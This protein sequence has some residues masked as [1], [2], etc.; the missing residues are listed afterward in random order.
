MVRLRAERAKLLG[1]ADFAHY[2]LDDAMAKTP[3]AVRE[4]LDTVW[5]GR[6]KKRSPTATPCRSS[7]L[8]RTA[9]LQAR[10]L[11]LALYYAEKLRQRLCDFDRR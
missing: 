1:F 4:L 11:G 6:G 3:A 9:E 10:R 5:R 7:A 8:P 2:R